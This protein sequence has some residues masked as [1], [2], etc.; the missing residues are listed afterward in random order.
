MDKLI[1]NQTSS[2]L[3][4]SDN[5]ATIAKQVFNVNLLTNW[6]LTDDEIIL[7]SRAILKHFPDVT[8]E[9]IEEILTR[10][11]SNDLEWNHYQG[12]QNIIRILKPRKVT[13]G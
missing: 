7:W 8:P 1:K 9:K 11:E 10:Y 5:E 4:F 12:V 3:A 6:K 13:Y 2:G